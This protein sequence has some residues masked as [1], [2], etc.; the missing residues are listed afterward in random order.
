M[1]TFAIAVTY[2]GDHIVRLEIN[3]E[4]DLLTAPELLDSVQCAAAAN[5]R[6]NIVVDLRDV[7]FIDPAGLDALVRADRGVRE[8]NAHMIVC[9]PSRTVQ[10]MLEMTGLDDVL[11]IRPGWASRGL[12]RESLN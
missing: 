10:C 12:T 1:A 2:G 11:D 4:V 9:N 6:C 5:D 8:L 3:G 7:S